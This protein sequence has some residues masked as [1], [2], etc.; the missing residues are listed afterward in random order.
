MKTF[1]EFHSNTRRRRCQIM[2]SRYGGTQ[3]DCPSASE[4]ASFTDQKTA[5]LRGQW[6]GHHLYP[7]VGAE[8]HLPHRVHARRCGC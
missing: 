4:I 7:C 1:Y 8:S 5:Q 6:C 2:L 3:L